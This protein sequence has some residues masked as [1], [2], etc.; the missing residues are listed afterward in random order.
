MLLSTGCSDSEIF[1]LCSEDSNWI[2]VTLNF[3]ALVT[4][5][6]DLQSK[7]NGKAVKMFENTG[8]AAV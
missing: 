7:A 4:W 1:P 8:S 5:K 6:E 3:C 2:K